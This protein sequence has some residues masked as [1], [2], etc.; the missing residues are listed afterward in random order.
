MENIYAYLASSSSL[1]PPGSSSSFLDHRATLRRHQLLKFLFPIEVFG[2]ENM[3]QRDDNSGTDKPPSSH[4]RYFVYDI[5]HDYRHNSNNSSSAKIMFFR[6][7]TRNSG[8]SIIDRAFVGV[9]SVL[10][11]LQVDYNKNSGSDHALTQRFRDVLRF[12]LCN[13][14]TGHA[15]GFVSVHDYIFL[16]AS[17]KEFVLPYS[18]LLFSNGGKGTASSPEVRFPNAL[19]DFFLRKVLLKI[20]QKFSSEPDQQKRVY[21]FLFDLYRNPYAH[22]KHITD[23]NDGDATTAVRWFVDKFLMRDKRHTSLSL[24]AA[25]AAG[26]EERNDFECMPVFVVAD[27]HCFSKCVYLHP[28][29]FGKFRYIFNNR[30]VSEYTT[31]KQILQFDDSSSNIKNT[32]KRK[33]DQ[34]PLSEKVF[35]GDETT[36]DDTAKK[37]LF[38]LLFENGGA[39]EM[40]LAASAFTDDQ[41][42]MLLDA[43]RS[44]HSL[45]DNFC[46]RFRVNSPLLFF[47]F[48][49]F[50]RSRFQSAAEYSDFVFAAHSNARRFCL[51]ADSKDHKT[52]AA[53][54]GPMFLVSPYF[55]LQKPT[56]ENAKKMIFYAED[57]CPESKPCIVLARK[58]HLSE[59]L[60]QRKSLCYC[61][62]DP[63]R[64]KKQWIY[65]NVVLENASCGNEVL[66]VKRGTQIALV[67][68]L[69]GAGSFDD[70]FISGLESCGVVA[71]RKKKCQ[72]VVIVDMTM[73]YY[74]LNF[75]E[76]KRFFEKFFR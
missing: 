34:Q 16:A 55:L 75:I 72:D 61:S 44:N 26:H 15:E 50:K 8:S 7:A 36:A 19:C 37:R 51:P 71:I 10:A 58:A 20:E 43:L 23:D 1:L 32:K 54:L 22:H 65:R 35:F 31:I 76:L 59:D 5:E 42:T 30:I 28:A 70:S 69:P 38:D 68:P 14:E 52:T 73:D 33:R 40:L 53:I 47:Y 2:F 57:A 63:G 18:P 41:K 64:I 39:E 21:S 13:C 12:Q 49:K 3:E 29:L 45:F 11:D 62:E 17:E 60:K 67:S 48:F 66:L 6:T 9:K 24:T 46:A 25:A 74:F 4:R 56:A 27:D